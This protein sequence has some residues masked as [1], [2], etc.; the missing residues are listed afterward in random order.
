MKKMKVEDIVEINQNEIELTLVDIDRLDF[1]NP[2]VPSSLSQIYKIKFYMTKQSW[3]DLGSPHKGEEISISYF[4]GR[5]KLISHIFA[6]LD[7][8]M[9]QA[10]L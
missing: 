10:I 3:R 4:L 6:E 1:I 8:K 5:G 7:V 9:E 2:D